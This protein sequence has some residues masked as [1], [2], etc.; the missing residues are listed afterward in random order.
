MALN[1]H[2]E[3]S[4]MLNEFD[5]QYIAVMV[6]RR[7]ALWNQM[8]TSQTYEAQIEYDKLNMRVFFLQYMVDKLRS[9]LKYDAILVARCENIV[10]L[11]ESGKAADMKKAIDKLKEVIEC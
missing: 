2:I 11:F 10:E 9:V 3:I 5:K 4:E 8:R 7:D 6:D 1:E